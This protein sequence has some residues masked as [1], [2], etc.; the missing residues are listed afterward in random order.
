MVTFVRGRIR[1]EMKNPINRLLIAAYRPALRVLVRGRY[2]V[3]LVVMALLAGDDLPVEPARVG[4]HAPS[5]R[6]L[7]PL[8]AHHRPRHLHRG[9]KA[10]G[11]GP[12]RGSCG[13]SPRWSG[14][15]A[16]PAGPRRP[17]IPRPS[18]C[19]RRSSCSSPAE[20]WRPGMTKDRLVEEMSKALELPGVQNAWTMPIKARVDMLTTGIRTPIGIKVFGKDLKDIAARRRRPRADPQGRP[21]DAIGLRRTGARRLLP[22]LRA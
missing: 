21:R 16:R 20:E 15:S 14:S 17:P 12:G 5:R 9:G 3:A 13:R 1:P 6:G 11:P 19:S 8:H 22:R 7:D 18:R 4:V 10:P 2:V